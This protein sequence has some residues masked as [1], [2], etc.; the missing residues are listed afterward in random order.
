MAE[1]ESILSN[2]N[3]EQLRAVTH[4]KGPLLIVAGA[5]TGKT[6]VLTRRIAW[7]IA[8]K[9]ARPEELLAL[10]FSDKASREMEERVDALVPYGY[11]PVNILTFHAFGQRLFEEH[12]LRL[13]LAPDAK[14]LSGAPLRL[15]LKKHLFELPLKKFRPLANPDRHV[16]D[17]IQHFSRAKDEAI[18]P[19]DYLKVAR[20]DAASAVSEA[21]LGSAAEQLELAEAYQAYDA[22]LHREGFMDHGDQ[23]MLMLRLLR[24]E[25]LVLEKTRQEFPWILVDEFQDTNT[26][27]FELIKL[28]APP[29]TRDNLTVV[30]DDDQA[31]YRFRGASL[32]NILD[33]KAAYK[34]AE[35]VVVTKNYRSKQ[36]ILEC[37]HRL[38]QFNN[39]ERLEARENLDKRLQAVAT[40]ANPDISGQAVFYQVFDQLSSELADL[41][42]RISQAVAE[43]KRSWRDHAILVRSNSGAEAVIQELNYRGIPSRFSGARGLYRQSEIRLCLGFLRALANPHDNLVLFE[44]LVGEVYR[45]PVSDLKALLFRA[46]AL[47][48]S[49]YQLVT[50]TDL[51]R[52][53]EDTELD[54]EAF[55]RVEKALSDLARFEQ[56]AREK[57]VAAALY[58]FLTESGVISRLLAKNGAALPAAERQV[59][60]LARFFEKIKVYDQVEKSGSYLSVIGY[61]D[62]LI[63]EGD[64]P[65]ASEAELDADAVSVSTVHMAKGLEWPVVFVVG[66]EDQHFPTSRRGSGLNLPASLGPQIHDER[67]HHIAEERRLYYVAI[68][69][70]QQELRLSYARDHG[71]KK[72]WKRSPFLQ[73][74]LNLGKDEAPALKLSQAEKLHRHATS[75][76][77]PLKEPLQIALPGEPLRLSYYPIDDYLTCPLKYKIAH[78]LRLKPPATFS[79]TYGNVMHKAVQ[80]FNKAGMEGRPFSLEDLKKAYT[81][82]WRSEGFYSREHEEERFQNGLKRLESFYE[83]EKNAQPRRQPI[84]VESRFEFKISPLDSVS[85]R[86]DRVDRDADGRVTVCDYKTSNVHDVKKAESEVAKSLQL[87]IYALAWR[88]SHGVLPDLVELYFLESGIR[89]SLKP[90]QAYIEAKEAEIK[91]A[92][93]GIREARFEAKPDFQTCKFCAYG[94]ICPDSAA[95]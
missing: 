29:G 76:G 93:K 51:T 17:L 48:K 65:P 42:S 82:G 38:I 50:R 22:I 90:D 2:L 69:R 21:E 55:E 64:D 10:T 34:N 72:L 91:L 59:S 75:D 80:E 53:G 95:L 7:L 19:E 11:A 44:F 4:G 35:T 40:P 83:D 13:G 49:L 31:I 84:G 78:G 54:P 5:G 3:P 39:P 57:G 73:E 32:A 27:Q 77:H 28:L 52:A 89:Q 61:L 62:A 14:V 15:F 46:S 9:A 12:A 26:V 74:T 16:A 18:T 25:P 92:F 43:G 63:E 88:G 87:A 45:T 66:L 30:G 23:L 81:E 60:N 79:I 37:A 33:F 36:D 70:A 41:S 1:T 58:Q 85:G 56:L 20:A 68:T 24:Q 47:N 6:T 71:G 86:M 8:T 94:Q 67:A